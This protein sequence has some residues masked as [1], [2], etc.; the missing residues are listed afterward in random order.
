MMK[1]SN[2]ILLSILAIGLMASCAE[3]KKSK[4]IIAPKPVAQVTNKPTQEM[5]G[6]EQSRDVEWLGNHY[7][8]VVKREADHELPIIQLDKT[9]KY[10]DNKITIRILRSDGTE[11]FN[12][13][14]TKAAFEGNLDKKTKSTGALLGIVFD[15]AEGNNLCFAASVGSPDITSDEYLPLVL[16]ISRMG[17]VSISK[18]QVLDTDPIPNP[19]LQPLLLPKK[20]QKM[21]KKEYKQEILLSARNLRLIESDISNHH[22]SHLLVQSANQDGAIHGKICPQCRIHHFHIQRLVLDEFLT[23]IGCD[24]CPNHSLPTIYQTSLLQRRLQSLV[25]QKLRQ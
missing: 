21:M 13:T 25:S 20:N 9:N 24:W 11:F 5:S 2:Y 6:Y 1:R 7:K 4:I 10:Y 12:H 16:K 14:F 19:P 3:K 18:D 8:V 15:K 22:A 17:A 23:A